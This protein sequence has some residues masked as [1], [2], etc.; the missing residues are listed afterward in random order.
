MNPGKPGILPSIVVVVFYSALFAI[1]GLW[2]FPPGGDVWRHAVPVVT[3]A[4]MAGAI[5]AIYVD[6]HKGAENSRRRWAS[7]QKKIEGLAR[8]SRPAGTG[9]WVCARDEGVVEATFGQGTFSIRECSSSGECV[10]FRGSYRQQGALIRLSSLELVEEIEEIKTLD[11]E[12]GTP[13]WCGF[14]WGRYFFNEEDFLVIRRS[15][16]GAM[17]LVSMSSGSLSLQKA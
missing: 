6:A 13:L 10:A 15:D 4:F 1:A 3:M 9:R 11:D 2:V 16:G 12:S 7:R 8:F 5:V 17:T 14:L